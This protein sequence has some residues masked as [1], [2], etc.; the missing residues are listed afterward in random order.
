MK[1]FGRLVVILALAVAA[2]RPAAA[3]QRTLDI[4]FIDVEG[5]QSTLV[6]TPSGQT[7]LIDTGFPGDGTFASLPGDPHKARDAN[8][9]LAAA[10]AAGVKRIDYLLITHFH[11]DHDGA[12][13][14]LAQLIPIGTFIDHDVPGPDA[15]A[16]V[17][18][19]Q[20]AFDRYARVRATKKHLVVKPGGTIPLAGV[21]TVVVSA[22]GETLQ[23]PLPGAG[24]A[25]PACGATPPP[26]QEPSENPRSTGV[27]LRFGRF[28]FLDVGDL[29]GPPLAAL[30]CP[31]NLIGATDVYL[32]AHHAGPDGAD[33][34]TFAAFAPRVAI[35]NN[36][37]RKGGSPEVLAAL[38]QV[39][40]LE[41]AWQLHRS[42]PPGPRFFTDDHVANLDES[43]AHW[44][45]V[46]AKTDGSFIVTNGRTGAAKVYGP[47]PAAALPGGR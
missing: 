46:S 45:K 29:S 9:I 42:L 6:V 7:L 35:L 20:G 27:L 13:P 14:E 10:R 32:V 21:N 39:R 43:T 44:L 24:A 5:G 41:D 33:P 26:A 34:A 38:H 15:E 36:G 2:P 47:R 4:Y 1:P 17:P 23:A 31:N 25:N 37:T 8:R 40:G 3:Q 12:V 11:A 19:T 30:A 28:T 16:R 22:A 18:G